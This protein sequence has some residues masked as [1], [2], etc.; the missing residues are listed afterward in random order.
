M[1]NNGNIQQDYEWYRNNGTKIDMNV[2]GKIE[3]ELFANFNAFADVQY[4]HIEYKM[5]GPDDDLQL[6][7]QEHKW[8][9]VN[10]KAGLSYTINNKHKTYLSFAVANREPTRTDLKESTKS[11]G[12][13][14]PVFETLYDVEAGYKLSEKKYTIGVNLFYMMYD[15]QLVQTGELNAVGYP[16]MTNVKESFRRGIEL[17]WGVKLLRDVDWQANFTLSQNR[18]ENYIEYAGH[19]DNN[20]NATYEA[21]ELGQTNIS[22]SP[23]LLG[24]SIFTLSPYNTNLHISWITKYVGEQYFDNTSSSARKLDDY[25]VN[26]LRINYAIPFDKG[27]ILNIQFLV[28]NIFDEKY[29]SAAY[30]G[31]WYEQNEEKTWAYYYPQAFRNFM[32]KVSVEF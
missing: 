24:A 11:G 2:F 8:G 31:N 9:F 26:N 25:I 10:P 13:Q 14:T 4:R 17:I 18:I 30:G 5:D 3:Y 15:N 20:W 28:N 27:P 19:Y 29:S 7:N 16:I 21:K 1:K 23:E 12:T 6:I 22:N 32:L